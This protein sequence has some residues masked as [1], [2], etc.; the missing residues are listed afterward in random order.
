MPTFQDNIKTIQTAIYGK[1]MRPAISEALTQSWNNV[2]AMESSVE[3]LNKRVDNLPSGGGGSGGG[4]T[5]D[6]NK[7]DVPTEACGVIVDDIIICV[8]SAITP[9][10]A[11]GDADPF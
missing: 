9:L 7:P 2:M 6:P 5:V 11:V 4:G 3:E 1:E 8:D 10:S